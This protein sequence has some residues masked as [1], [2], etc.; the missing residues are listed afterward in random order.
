LLP[1]SEKDAAFQKKWEGK[2]VKFN[3]AG[4]AINPPK[5]MIDEYNGMKDVKA[6]EAKKSDSDVLKDLNI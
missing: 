6:P 1:L 3:A 2:G 5:E 4:E